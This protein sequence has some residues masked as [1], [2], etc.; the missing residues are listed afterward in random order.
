MSTP[1]QAPAAADPGRKFRIAGIAT[2]GA[3]A[4]LILIG[5]IQGAR[6]VGAANDIEDAARAGMAFDP[7]VE[8]RGQSAE[9]AQWWCLG[10]GLV[11]GAAGGGL[12]YYGNRV[13]A[14]A[15]TTTWR[16][17]LAPVVAPSM[18]GATLRITF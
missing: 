7:A 11:A 16:V 1:P 15:E 2:G 3:G 13:T 8:K 14:A 17:S 12:W 10:L 6:A 9:K 5:I 4:A 18:N